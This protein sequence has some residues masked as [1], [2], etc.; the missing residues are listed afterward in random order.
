MPNT[1]G[2]GC[3]GPTIGFAYSLPTSLAATFQGVDQDLRPRNP[4]REGRPCVPP[5]QSSSRS[6]ARSGGLV[7][8][9]RAAGQCTSPLRYLINWGA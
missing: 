8:P 5:G 6:G 2:A 3:P 7:P 4:E 1:A 9:L